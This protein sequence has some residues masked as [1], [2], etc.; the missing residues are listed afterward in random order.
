MGAAK[1]IE[2]LE[3]SKPP[4]L[5]EIKRTI[6]RSL[7]LAEVLG[8]D[9]GPKRKRAINALLQVDQPEAPEGDYEFHSQ[10]IIDIL[11]DL[12]VLAYSPLEFCRL[13]FHFSQR[14]RGHRTRSGIQTWCLSQ[15]TNK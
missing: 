9:V 3:A 13:S 4:A 12:D 5:I 2:A 7:A 10:G 6:R 8:L 1:A 11:K 15:L 14:R